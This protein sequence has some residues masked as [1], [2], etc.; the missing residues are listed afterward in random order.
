MFWDATAL[1]VSVE[2]Y[3]TKEIEDANEKKGD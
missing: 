3:S 2:D 1:K